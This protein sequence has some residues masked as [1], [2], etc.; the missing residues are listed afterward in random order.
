MH[1]HG[2]DD[3]NRRWM[4]Y[5]DWKRLSCFEE[6]LLSRVVAD[7]QERV[8][9][10]T[11]EVIAG[12]LQCC[13]SYKS[14]RFLNVDSFRCGQLPDLY[15]RTRA[16]GKKGT[17]D[18]RFCGATGAADMAASATYMKLIRLEQIQRGE[19]PISQEVMETLELK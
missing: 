17:F 11:G 1:L 12:V 6:E 19:T 7:S 18:F 9:S 14:I 3:V 13:V 2:V 16:N 8:G 4:L 15:F 10:P 5:D